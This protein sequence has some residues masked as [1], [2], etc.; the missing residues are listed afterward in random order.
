MRCNLLPK[1][2]LS[3]AAGPMRASI[4]SS[5]QRAV[6]IPLPSLYQRLRIL[7]VSQFENPILQLE[8][9]LISMLDASFH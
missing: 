6:N 5:G 8:F 7:I 9:Y 3:G 4:S 1:Y 2:T